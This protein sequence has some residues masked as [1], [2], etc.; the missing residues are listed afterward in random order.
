[1]G[2]GVPFFLRQ[3][4]DIDGEEIFPFDMDEAIEMRTRR[5][6]IIRPMPDEESD[7][8]STISSD[9]SGSTLNDLSSVFTVPITMQEEVP[10]P[11]SVL[12][13]LPQM[14]YNRRT[15]KVDS[16]DS[17]VNPIKSKSMGI[18]EDSQLDKSNYVS[19]IPIASHSSQL[20]TSTNKL[21]DLNNTN[22]KTHPR[23]SPPPK[24]LPYSG[25]GPKAFIDQISV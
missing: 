13:S 14:E 12:A 23:K 19:L 24:P 20:C 17:P 18:N 4:E 15:E 2:D 21:V 25:R 11:S 7:S 5:S 22:L 1:M 8:A 6:V 9:S 16:T 3:Q 10:L